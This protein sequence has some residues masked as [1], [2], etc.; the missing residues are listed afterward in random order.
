MPRA[1]TV[2]WGSLSF[3]AGLLVVG[4]GILAAPVHAADKP[5]GKTPLCA[6]ESCHVGIVDRKVLHAPV[7]DRRCL[8]CHE[9]V[10]AADHTFRLKADGQALCAT[11]H[12]SHE[13][14]FVHPP[15]RDGRCTDCHDAHGSEQP[16]LLL[17]RPEKLC[18]RCHK[19]DFSARKFVHGPVA[20]GACVV[21]HT[22]HSS[23][24]PNL[25]VDSS[26]KLCLNC[27]EDLAPTPGAI[28]VH[29][30][31]PMASGCTSCHDPHAS[32]HPRQLKKDVPDL[33]F[34]CHA[35]IRDSIA[36]AKVKHAPALEEGGCVKCHTPHFSSLPKLQKEAQPDL[37]LNCHN[38]ALPLES[39]EKLTN[40]AKL[41]AENPDHHGPIREGACTACHR[42][43]GGDIFRLLYKAYPPEFYAPFDEKRYE[44]CFSCHLTDMVE[45]RNGRGVT[46]FR[47]GD[48]NLHWVH[49][50]REKGRTCR[51]CHEVHAS[52][53]PFHIREAVPFGRGGWE[54]PINY[55]KTDTGGQCAPG[56][57]KLR[58]YNRNAPAQK[59]PPGRAQSGE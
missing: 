45:K 15:V 39:G 55:T 49:V 26:E 36:A 13:K 37:C 52:K 33:C 9:Y 54:L 28:G 14:A 27:H 31:A 44:L 40:M 22:S 34:T 10:S 6:T 50:N 25:L 59:N 57:H 20:V 1:G 41:L 46:G 32:D 42:P 24:Y 12:E 35:G 19:Q 53:R 4:L 16:K 29:L 21:C 8:D 23:A 43:H 18:V 47:N 48:L 17:D 30:H 38:A 56:C 2:G 7:R 3:G 58:T 51:A 5:V 11:C